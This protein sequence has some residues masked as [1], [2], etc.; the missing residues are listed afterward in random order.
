MSPDSRPV[1]GAC[2][3]QKLLVPSLSRADV[4]SLP[5]AGDGCKT[6]VL[7][8]IRK[9]GGEAWFTVPIVDIRECR[10]DSDLCYRWSTKSRTGATAG[11]GFE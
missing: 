1:A 8:V 3:C 10:R 6:R 4:R 2:R 11:R 7:K 9:A 5:V